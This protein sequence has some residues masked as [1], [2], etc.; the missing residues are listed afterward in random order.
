MRGT[1]NLDITTE[2]GYKTKN[3]K[4][5]R[6]EGKVLSIRD[7]LELT[8]EMARNEWIIN[9]NKIERTNKFFFKM[10]MNEAIESGVRKALN[11]DTDSDIDEICSKYQIPEKL[12]FEP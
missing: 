6:V 3:D 10:A 5:I 11:L 7:L 9:R 8:K 2:Q 1:R 4:R 12:P